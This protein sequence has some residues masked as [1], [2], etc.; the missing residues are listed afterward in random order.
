MNPDNIGIV[1]NT[2]IAVLILFVSIY[3]SSCEKDNTPS[4]AE[5]EFYLL[6]SFKTK[7]GTCKIIDSSAI[8]SD[9]ALVKYDEIISYDMRD[10]SFKVSDRIADWLN[11][12]ENNRIHTRA[13]A[14]TIDKE[15]IYTGYFWAGF[16]S[17]MCGW[18]VIDPL[19]YSGKNE[20]DV[21]LGYPGLIAR[22][23]ISDNRND[24]RLLDVLRMDKKLI[25]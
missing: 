1:K 4:N 24:K 3:I 6:S 18:I 2:I 8:M 7:D 12:F 23:T 14:L 22:D 17:A 16:S 21:R 19:N 15:V 25:E 13:F 9:S 5:V 20:L 10:Y 11:D